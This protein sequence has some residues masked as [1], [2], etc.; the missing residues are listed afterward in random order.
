V[1]A[2]TAAAMTTQPSDTTGRAG[3]R[4]KPDDIPPL[5]NPKPPEAAN[6]VAALGPAETTG[7]L[8]AI[9]DNEVKDAN[10]Y[11]ARGGLAYRSGD[12][13]LALVDYDLAIN[14]DPNF[15]DAY[16]DRA[17][18]LHRMGDLKHAFADIAQAKR[19]DD[20]RRSQ[21]RP[22]SADPH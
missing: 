19:I 14:L 12:L 1:Q 3:P 18:V 13:S 9:A 11:R 6:E 2:L 21:D 4:D 5:N 7:S 8:P 15:S 10:Y 16:I 20:S 22:L 17:I